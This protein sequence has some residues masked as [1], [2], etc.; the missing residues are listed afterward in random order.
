M[1]GGVIEEAQ[2]FSH[3]ARGQ[4]RVLTAEGAQAVGRLARGKAHAAA[5]ERACAQYAALGR[6][7]PLEGWRSGARVD[8]GSRAALL[9]EAAARDAKAAR[10]IR[11]IQVDSA[12]LE[13]FLQ[14]VAFER[15]GELSTTAV[16]AAAVAQGK[17]KEVMDVGRYDK[18]KEETTELLQRAFPAAKQA[19]AREWLHGNPGDA[20]RYGG[21]HIRAV[22]PHR[23]EFSVGTPA[24]TIGMPVLAPSC[25][26]WHTDGDGY[27]CYALKRVTGLF[28]LA[29]LEGVQEVEIPCTARIFAAARAILEEAQAPVL[30]TAPQKFDGNFIVALTTSWYFDIVLSLE[31]RLGVSAIWSLDGSRRFKPEEDTHRASCA[32]V[33]HDG[34][35]EG[36]RIVADD[37]YTTEM[38]AQLEAL[39]L[40]GERRVLI[41]FDASSPIE[42]WLRWRSL[43]D[44]QKVGYYQDR[45]LGALDTAIN[46]FEAICFVW[47]HSHD[48]VTINEWADAEAAKRLADETFMSA[49]R[50]QKDHASMTFGSRTSAATQATE[51]L[52]TW[53]CARLRAASHETQ[54]K[55]QSD[56]P[57]PALCSADEDDIHAL[58]GSRWFPG[59]KTLGFGELGR[60]VRGALCP[61]CGRKVACTW[62]HALTECEGL[63]EERLII[64]SAVLQVVVQLDTTTAQ[65]PQSNALADVMRAGLFGSQIGGG[66]VTA[67]DGRWRWATGEERA[68][69]A[70]PSLGSKA[71][72][73]LLRG[74]GMLWDAPDKV[75]DSKEAK[76]VCKAAALAV[77]AWMRKASKV[78]T[79]Q[80]DA[81]AQQFKAQRGVA[82][83]WAVWQ[84]RTRAAGPR[85]L[86]A[87][88][89]ARA[90]MSIVARAAARSGLCGGPG[91]LALGARVA[92]HWRRR[93]WEIE[94]TIPTPLQ[95]QL[96][97]AQGDEEL[98]SFRNVGL[99]AHFVV[100][101]WRWRADAQR[102]AVR[103]R[104]VREQIW[105]ECKAA[106]RALLRRGDGGDLSSTVPTAVTARYEEARYRHIRTAIEIYTNRR[107]GIEGWRTALAA[108]EQT[109]SDF[110]VWAQQQGDY[111]SRAAEARFEAS[112]R[113]RDGMAEGRWVGG[114]WVV[115]EP[116]FFAPWCAGCPRCRAHY[117]RERASRVPRNAE[118]VLSGARRRAVAA[119]RVQRRRV[120]A[121]ARARTAGAWQEQEAA[122]AQR[123]GAAA[124]LAWVQRQRV[125][126]AED[127]TFRAWRQGVRP[128]RRSVRSGRAETKF[129]FVV[130][131]GYDVRELATWRARR[132]RRGLGT[133]GAPSKRQPDEQISAEAAARYRSRKEAEMKA[134]RERA[135][136]EEARRKLEEEE[137]HEEAMAVADARL[138][139]LLGSSGGREEGGEGREEGG[140]EKREQLRRR[141]QRAAASQAAG[142]GERTSGGSVWV[143]G[144]W[145]RV[146]WAANVMPSWAS[147]RGGR[148]TRLSASAAAKARWPSLFVSSAHI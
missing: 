7:N 6:Q 63:R 148:G 112:G 12:A 85:R 31:E 44:R 54:W 106:G 29:E 41:C 45:M 105:E 1:L 65:H 102:T 18:L 49:R 21:P 97:A 30:L 137:E 88:R 94:A 33:R 136:R 114:E 118:V 5:W 103:D 58:L 40:E 89:E 28:E 130:R 69:W 8:D 26:P 9:E 20:A 4:P 68:R 121:G 61:C 73:E 60:R 131:W 142:V 35:A 53:V 140:W 50:P 115:A 67:P 2:L 87:L 90:A 59:D 126:W 135:S 74:L 25:T 144:R 104:I 107:C 64:S 127:A 119:Q 10:P 78:F 98:R 82:D 77:L 24:A 81:I 95:M 133:G 51:A 139:R 52:Q 62:L 117:L 93:R 19:E 113:V 124:E 145:V 138:G 43:H 66:Y 37:S 23:E 16:P 122:L 72:F 48:G 14:R 55:S 47:I 42:A 11:D 116:E 99:A 129:L 132:R 141:R 109:R 146:G 125:K 96:S 27:V 17:A 57:L 39:S 86:G 56:L 123:Q 32:A 143:G 80:V 34:R 101:A 83:V 36:G 111:V 108:F 71:A 128:R 92:R 79:P 15:K 134:R 38:A 147:A 13:G 110:F 46:R 70:V 75:R 91:E 100:A 3:D 22:L 76:R 120:A 84:R